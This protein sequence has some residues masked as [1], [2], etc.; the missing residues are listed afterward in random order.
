MDIATTVSFIVLGLIMLF[1]F[2]AFGLVSIQEGERRAARVAFGAAALTSLSFFLASLLP[3]ALKLVILGVVAVAVGGTGVGVACTGSGVGVA[4]AGA[5]VRAQAV[6]ARMIPS[7]TSTDHNL[8]PLM[9]KPPFVL[10]IV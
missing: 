1:G 9:A 2:G 6:V 3:V 4:G 8:F 10:S 7:V 5:G